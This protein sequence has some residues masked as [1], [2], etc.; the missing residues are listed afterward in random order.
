[1]RLRL[2]ISGMNKRTAKANLKPAVPAVNFPGEAGIEPPQSGYECSTRQIDFHGNIF[3]ISVEFVKAQRCPLM[4]V[5][6]LL[7]T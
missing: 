7:T 5:F 3:I 2:W 4:L 1:M 6:L